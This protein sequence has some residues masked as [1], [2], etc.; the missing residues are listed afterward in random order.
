MLRVYG[1]VYCSISFLSVYMCVCMSQFDV[2]W[3]SAFAQVASGLLYYCTPP[4]CVPDILGALAVWRHTKKN[5]GSYT[6]ILRTSE[7]VTCHVISIGAGG[8]GDKST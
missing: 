7:I 3:W 1:C 4:L 2:H 8:E 6:C 5:A